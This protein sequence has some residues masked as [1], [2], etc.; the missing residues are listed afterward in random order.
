M[1]LVEVSKTTTLY[2]SDRGQGPERESPCQE[3]L[4]N[5]V[6]SAR[7]ANDASQAPGQR[8]HDHRLEHVL[9]WYHH[10]SGVMQE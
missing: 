2:R 8:E 4:R 9:I 3:P 5:E 10:D 6:G 1:P 7:Q